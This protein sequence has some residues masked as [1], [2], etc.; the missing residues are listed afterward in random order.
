M[1]LQAA[2]V[3]AYTPRFAKADAVGLVHFDGVPDCDVTLQVVPPRY[4]GPPYTLQLVDGRIPDP[5]T[6]AA[7]PVTRFKIEVVD[8]SGVRVRDVRVLTHV[9]ANPRPDV[10]VAAEGVYEADVACGTTCRVAAM[11]RRLAYGEIT[12][13]GDLCPERC[14][15]VALASPGD[16]VAAHELRLLVIDAISHEPIPSAHVSVEF[17]AALFGGVTVTTDALRL[18][19]ME[20]NSEG[21]LVLA[22]FPFDEIRFWVTH[23]DYHRTAGFEI[24]QSPQVRHGVAALSRKRPA[25]TITCRPISPVALAFRDYS[26]VGRADGTI[27][28]SGFD[29]GDTHVTIHYTPQADI[30]RPCVVRGVPVGSRGVI[31]PLY[32]TGEL[33]V[34]PTDPLGR[35]LSGA[36][37]TVQG[38]DFAGATWKEDPLGQ[39]VV[40]NVPVGQC[41]VWVLV[42]GRGEVGPLACE[43]RAGARAQIHARMGEPL[44]LLAVRARLARGGVL[45]GCR[46]VVVRPDGEDPV[47]DRHLDPLTGISTLRTR[48]DGRC[49]FAAS[50][51]T[52]LVGLQS[53]VRLC[54]AVVDWGPVFGL[55]ALIVPPQGILD[56][57]LTLSWRV[58]VS[59]VRPGSPAAGAGLREGDIVVSWAGVPVSDV[60]DCPPFDKPIIVTISREGDTLDLELPA[61]GEGLALDRLYFEER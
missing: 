35:T 10:A 58:F 16:R 18:P 61:D 52:L 3:E 37:L 28:L 55:R 39:L 27:E 53:P 4:S 32:A 38:T 46:V 25:D 31:L 7:R 26:A 8:V 49:Y 1:E 60:H 24:P 51:Q 40:R 6:L 17:H 14:V 21:T 57:D 45:E 36:L 33:L 5:I 15:R 34:S 47:S 23:P 41:D 43:I 44:A 50:P 13:V 22:A 54:D 2:P 11:D 12:L 20:T 29:A 48:S 30:T 19:G 9:E 42:P 59:D 56:I